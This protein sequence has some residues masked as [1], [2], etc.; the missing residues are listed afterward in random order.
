M[1]LCMHEIPSYLKNLAVDFDYFLKEKLSCESFFV[2][3]GNT[4][5]SSLDNPWYDWWK[6]LK[7]L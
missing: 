4:V 6:I 7:G 1:E 3:K 2:F 5:V